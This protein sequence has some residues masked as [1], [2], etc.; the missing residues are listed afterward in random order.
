VLLLLGYVATTPVGAN[1]VGR[2]TPFS[3]S[4]FEIGEVS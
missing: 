4:T 2:I 1:F 3:V